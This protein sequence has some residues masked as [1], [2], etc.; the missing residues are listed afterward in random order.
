MEPIHAIEYELTTAQAGEVHRQLLG[1][2][3]RRAWRR[4][5]PNCALATVLCVL[6]IALAF[7]G[8]ILPAVAG[9]LLCLVTFFVLIGEFMRLS[10]ARM[11]VGMA[12]LGLHA[13][14]RR[15][16]VEFTEGHV[17]LER[18]HFHGRGEWS[19]LDEVVVL[20]PFHRLQGLD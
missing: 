8:W 5:I 15:V 19:E 9:G 14:D 4:G 2:E 13:E 18:E 20:R 17:R 6:L 7:E 10:R 3:L 1:W 16:R 11:A 12:L